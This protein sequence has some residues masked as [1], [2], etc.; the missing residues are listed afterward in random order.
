M[1]PAGSTQHHLW[2]FLAKKIKLESDQD[3]RSD[4]QLTGNKEDRVTC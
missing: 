2:S 4:Y 3:S 1:L